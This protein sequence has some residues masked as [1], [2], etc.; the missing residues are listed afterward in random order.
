MPSQKDLKRLVRSRM[1]KTGESY[2]TARLQ[3]LKKTARA[4]AAPPNA[5]NGGPEPADYAKLA[6][7]SDAALKAKTGGDW[8]R[9]VRTLDHAGAA[10]MTH[11]EIAKL[12]RSQYQVPDWWTQAVTVG[13]E[14]I[15]GLRVIGQGRDGAFAASKSKTIS[16]PVGALYRALTD[17]RTRERWLDAAVVIRTPVKDK[18]VRMTWEDKT[19]VAVFLVKKAAAKTQVTIEHGKL[20]DRA[21]GERLKKYWTERLVALS[22]LVRAS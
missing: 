10:R 3:L 19:S 9:W 20:A 7:M 11:R 21:A 13:Y 5:A 16:A 2:A 12:V 8:E 17:K 14:R 6:G 15:R 4:K 22:E 18:S 1:Q